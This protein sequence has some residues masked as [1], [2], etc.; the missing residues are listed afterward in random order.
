MASSAGS[1]SVATA[2]SFTRAGAAAT[3]G[4]TSIASLAGEVEASKIAR[5]ATLRASRMMRSGIPG[6]LNGLD[7][8]RLNQWKKGL[9]IKLTEDEQA[10]RNVFQKRRVIRKVVRRA[11][12]RRAP[13][14]RAPVRRAPMR[15]APVRRAPARRY[16]KSY[17]KTFARYYRK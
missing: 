1:G 8:T 12:M 16:P 14:R 2:V 9:I 13:M 3:G 11:P 5:R 15:R 17:K 7:N 4:Q 10:A 6:W